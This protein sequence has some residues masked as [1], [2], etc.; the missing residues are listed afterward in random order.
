MQIVFD[1]M[2]KLFENTFR[3]VNIGLA[4]ELAI[5]CDKLGRN[6][7]SRTWFTKADLWLNHFGDEMPP[8]GSASAIH[9][10]NW[11]EAQVLRNQVAATLKAR[12][13]SQSLP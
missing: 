5:M 1:A 10:H 7:E 12:A 13:T 2:A 11:L 8:S 3:A 9:L 4:N 6:A